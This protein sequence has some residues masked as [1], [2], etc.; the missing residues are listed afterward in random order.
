[1]HR[2]GCKRGVTGAC[3]ALAAGSE[4]ITAV[5]GVVLAL[6]ALHAVPAGRRARAVLAL[7]AGALVPLV[8]I[9]AYHTACFGV[10]WRT[11][12][13]FIQ[14][15]EFARGHASGLL[16]VNAP[17]ATALHGLLFGERRGLFF[18]SPVALVA[19][20]FT[21]SRAIAQRDRAARAGLVAMMALLFANGGYYMWW[22]GAA[23][24]PRHLV[25]VLGFLSFGA[26][27]AFES[28]RLRWLFV[29]LALVSFANVLVLTAVG[30]E[31]PE[32]GN[33]LTDYAYPRLMSGGLAGISG[34]SN[35]ALRLGLARA[36]TLGP[37]LVWILMGGRFLVRLLAP[38][39][40]GDE[41]ASKM[42]PA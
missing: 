14:R 24:G 20:W 28:R 10:P 30:L 1:M 18:I 27:A 11:G 37:F 42:D 39:P 40:E 17:N 31:G 5:P 35:L 38:D 7:G 9:C 13:S 12:Y 32:Q 41:R 6:F 3:L 15:A 29:P 8:V 22:G 33:L 21:A 26:A 16:G 36:A 34:A 4:Y 23:A 2:V 25:P 19:A